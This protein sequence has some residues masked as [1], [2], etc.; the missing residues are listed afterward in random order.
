MPSSETPAAVSKTKSLTALE[1]ELDID[2]LVSA[3]RA[4]DHNSFAS[5][6]EL[7]RPSL[8][9]HLYIVCGDLEL[10]RE[11]TQTTFT[12]AFNKI[13]STRPGKLYW[14]AWIY[15]IANNIIRDLRRRDQILKTFSLDEKIAHFEDSDADEY[16]A[17]INGE[18]VLNGS[19]AVAENPADIYERKEASELLSLRLN[20]I[21]QLLDKD[22]S[23]LL[24]L[25][26]QGHTYVEIAGLLGISTGDVK[27]GL[28]RARREAKLLWGTIDA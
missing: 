8:Q 11:I 27:S 28:A 14:K 16:I 17:I 20:T 19:H 4:G 5:L 21:M 12:K 6:C 25:N 1:R 22:L 13:G 9:R 3:A 7:T 2:K 23:N 18:I 10:A 26:S 24:W 15:T